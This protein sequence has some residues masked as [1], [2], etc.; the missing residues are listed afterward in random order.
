MG[1]GNRAAKPTSSP[2]SCGA[3]ALVRPWEATTTRSASVQTEGLRLAAGP[4]ALTSESVTRE[5]A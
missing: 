5:Q 3:K 2:V 4:F 1:L